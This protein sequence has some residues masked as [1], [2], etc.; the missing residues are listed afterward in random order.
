MEN[1]RNFALVAHVDHGKS[2]LCDRLIEICGGLEKRQ[3]RNQ[4]LDTME[5]ERE[6]GI[7][8]KAQTARLNAELEGRSYVLNLLDTPGHMDF[9]YEVSRSLAAVEGALL[10]VDACQGIQAQTIANAWAA[11]EAGVEIIP[12]F[13]KIDMAAADPSAVAGQLED[14]LGLDCS[15]AVEVSAKTGRG[16]DRLLKA[17]I[18]LL[19]RPKATPKPRPKPW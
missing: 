14:A 15:S 4:T 3:M 8:I 7:T 1:I 11:V 2:T 13:N 9:S 16:L 18:T 5:I 10:I 17:L 12:V 6:R 19:P